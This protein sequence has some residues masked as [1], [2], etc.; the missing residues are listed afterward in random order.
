MEVDVMSTNPHNMWRRFKGRKRMFFDIRT[1]PCVINLNTDIPG[2]AFNAAIY[3]FQ[4]DPTAA[5]PYYQVDFG[6]NTLHTEDTIT[7]GA[8][9]SSVQLYNS[10]TASADSTEVPIR[11]FNDHIPQHF[12]IRIYGPG[13][14]ATPTTLA[15]NGC[16]VF[17]Q[18]DFV[19]E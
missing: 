11:F 1:N 13:E 2:H 18:Y 4:I 14:P 12:T 5:Q 3:R 7:F 9:S 16:Q 8:K 19:E 6:L 17:I 15:A 10:G